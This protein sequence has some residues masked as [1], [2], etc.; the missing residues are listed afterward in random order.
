MWISGSPEYTGA[1]I[2]T[3]ETAGA[4]E[5]DGSVGAAEELDSVS[6][7]SAADTAEQACAGYPA[8]GVERTRSGRHRRRGASRSPLPRIGLFAQGELSALWT[9]QVLSRAGDQV[10]QVAIAIL[11]YS[12]TRSAFL[13][14]LAYALTYLSPVLG[15]RALASLGASLRPRN[16]MIVLDLTRA[17]ML[18]AMAMTHLP[19]PALCVLL[20]AAVALGAPFS[21]ARS[22]VL[23]DIA[24]RGTIV[25]GP[26]ASGIRHQAGQALG[27]L[28]G[29]VAVAILGPRSAL[30]IDAL[31]FA[32]S[33]GMLACWV[34]SDTA[35][36]QTAAGN[37][38]TRTAAGNAETPR[39]ALG[40]TSGAEPEQVAAVPGEAEPASAGAPPAR[41]LAAASATAPARVAAAFG[42][43]V[44][45]TLLLLGWLAGCYVVPECLAAPYARLTG[46]GALTVGLLMA[47]MPA[48]AV[49]G[50]LALARLARPSAVTRLIGWL[51]MLSCAP[52]IFSALRPP[53]WILLAL[54]ALAGAGTGY[55]LAA[56]AAFGRAAQARAAQV[57][58]VSGGAVPDDG[59]AAALNF[60]GSG[61]VLVQGMGFIVAGAAA[62]LVGPRVTVALAGLLGL[63]AAATLAGSW[64]R[65]RQP[66]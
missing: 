41:Q 18:A 50:G 60:A 65:Q 43:P 63:T 59:G 51:A 26:T 40:Q 8:P 53:L 52:L 55:Q 19:P 38:A 10:A 15:G 44:L 56:A 62:Q 5:A 22:A 64:A 14:A 37:A 36:E 11:V 23:R 1:G 13:T 61:L 46:G 4:A 17:L 25:P 32:L 57:S 7:E 6:V 27:F 45:R 58:A 42:S 34:G 30:G 49:V 21:T 9:A 48:G 33:A 29:A 47:A 24:P 28:V 12:Q 16:L 66:G 3:A 39:P 20:F 35:A 54:W 31:T 2:G